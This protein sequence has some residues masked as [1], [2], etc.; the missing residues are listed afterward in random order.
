MTGELSRGIARWKYSTGEDAG[1]LQIDEKT[2]EALLQLDI[3]YVTILRSI[4]GRGYT[5]DFGCAVL[6]SEIPIF[7]TICSNLY[8]KNVQRQYLVGSFTG[9]VPS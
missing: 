3:E 6:V 1:Y 2:L 9:A 5:Y 4:D 8:G 7:V